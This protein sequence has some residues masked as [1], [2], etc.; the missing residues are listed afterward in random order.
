VSI[1]SASHWFRSEA[2]L[3]A[4]KTTLIDILGGKDKSGQITGT[5][6]YTNS[7]GD[8][9]KRPRI[10]FVDQADVLP[11]TLTVQEALTFAARLRMPE[12]VS[13]AEKEAKVF[14]V[15]Q[16]LGLVDIKDTRIGSVERRGISGGEARRVS[17]G[18]ELVASP[19]ILVLDEPTSGL[20]KSLTTGNVTKP[21]SI[22]PRFSVGSQSCASLARSR[23]SPGASH[24]VH[25]IRPP[26]QVG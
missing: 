10:G 13:I 26:A 2:R 5:V 1:G 25:C 16:Q 11:S 14:E 23:T 21:V 17:I 9:I 12:W 8:P 20:S 24:S 6:T 7:T 3:G 4:G 18:L 22:R 15:L 19:D